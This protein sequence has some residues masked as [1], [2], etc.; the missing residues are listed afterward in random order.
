MKDLTK[1][2]IFK[3]FFTFGLPLVLSGVLTQAYSLIDSAIAGHFLGEVGLASTSATTPLDTFISS[4]F[5]G[6][7]VGF[8]VYIA[9]LFS[10]KEYHKLKSAFY[11]C[12]VLILTIG[13]VMGVALILLYEPLADLLKIDGALRKDSFL[14]FSTLNAGRGVVV[15]GVLLV[16]TLNAMG[17]SGFTFWMSLLSG[18]LNVAG[19]ILSVILL[20]MGVTGIAL[21]TLLS[22]L[23][24]NLLYLLKIRACFKQLGDTQPVR[25]KFSY[26]KNS[27]PYA[28][29]NM[30]Q[31]SVMYLVGLLVSPLVNGM[32]VSATASYSVVSHIYNLV[33]NV[34]QNATR[35]VSNYSAQCVGSKQYGKIKKGVG[36]GLLQ[37]FAFGTPF[38]LG[39]VF[40]REAVCGIFLKADASALVKEYS[41]AFCKVYLPFIYFN[42]VNNLFHALYRGVKAMGHLFFTSLLG[43]VS[44][45]ICSVAL[46]PKMGM[47][48]FYL[49]WVLSW[50]IEAVVTTV[51]YFMG[52]WKPRVEEET[53]A[54]VIEDK[55]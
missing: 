11:T 33:A 26:M 50:I 30:A 1:G 32:G 35:T 31:Q 19:N 41:Y 38:I 6:F 43:A 28:L 7:C 21:S 40:F 53:P 47:E 46:I 17:V 3:T 14:Y 18:V 42:I 25:L 45:L 5:W 4:M 15:L 52:K 51:L 9:R 16:F 24:V 44:R 8:S 34:Y 13:T 2:N 12:L 20:N 54:K 48:G 27:V 55:A 36:V 23:I 39:C 37:G 10:S 29:P 22:S 49:G